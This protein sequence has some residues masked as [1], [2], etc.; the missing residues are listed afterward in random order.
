MPTRHPRRFAPLA[1]PL[2]L[3]LIACSEGAEI[4]DDTSTPPASSSAAGAPTPVSPP[5]LEPDVSPAPTATPESAPAT[6]VATSTPAA[7]EPPPPTST[8]ERQ[9]PTPTPAPLARN[10]AE[11]P[12]L[13]VAEAAA[14]VASERAVLVDVRDPASWAAQHIAG[15]LHA[16]L[17]ELTQHVGRLPPDRLII[18]YCA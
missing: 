6:P 13:S 14:L 10:E 15:A 17:G 18:T 3:L 2:L 7:P 9:S 16:P 12:R 1:L 5:F 8:P 11:V 4:P